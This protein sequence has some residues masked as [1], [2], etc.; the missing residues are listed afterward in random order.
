[1]WF[2]LAKKNHPFDHTAF[3]LGTTI[4]KEVYV[5]MVLL[6][7]IMEDGFVFFTNLKSKKGQHFNANKNLSMCFYWESIHKQIRIV[8]KGSVV[9]KK[10]SDDYFNSRPRGSQ[11]GAWVSKQSSEIPSF[12]YLK[13]RKCIL[14][15]SL[16]ITRYLDQTIGRV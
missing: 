7:I 5:R 14:K 2:N 10:I 16:K 6:K 3:A 1:M 9:S 4:N 12:D 13:K 8:G 15:K 11:I